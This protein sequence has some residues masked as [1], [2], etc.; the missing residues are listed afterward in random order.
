MPTE[1]QRKANRANA[2][3]STGPRTE[4]GK[5][6]SSLNAVKTGLT[7]RTVLL[8]TEDA[9]AYQQN[10]ARYQEQYKPEGNQ[11]KELT[12][13][14]ADT[15]W[16]LNRIPVLEQ[17]IYAIGHR[18]FAPE[19]ENEDPSLRKALIETKTFLTYQRQ[20]NNL[21]IQEARLRRQYDKHLAELNKLQ[22]DRATR[23]RSQLGTLVSLYRDA[24]QT[25]LPFD[26]QELGL[27][28]TAAEVK[29][30]FGERQKQGRIQNGTYYTDQL[31]N[32]A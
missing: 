2:Q 12:Q 16:R 30:Y 5:A 9:E 17:G 10:I 26:P 18:E 31:R 6:K 13:S 19:F 11:E 14:L 7:G 1:A 28:F 27:E 32:A 24:Q 21:S 29:A 22:Q 3:L 4:Q 20:L 15:Q 8:P 25:G 23:K